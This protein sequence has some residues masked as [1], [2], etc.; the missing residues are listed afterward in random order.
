MRI[1]RIAY[2]WPPPWD[3]LAPA[4]YEMTTAQAKLGHKITVF[5]GRWPGAGDIETFSGVENVTFWREPL[6]GTVNLTTSILMFVYYLMWRRK[7]EVDVIHSHGHFGIW[8]YWWRNFLKQRKPDA[9]E[10]KTPLVVHFHN[11]VK[12]RAANLEENGSAIKDFSKKIAWPLAEKSDRWAV[13]NADA[14]IF[15]SE[16]TRNEAIKFYG[17]DASKCFVVESGVNVDLFKPVGAEE[18]YKTRSDLGFVQYDKI[19]LNHGV[20]V[21]RKNVHLLL[22]AMAKLPPNY[23]LLLVGPSPDNEYEITLRE[24]ISTYRLEDRVVRVGYTPYP[25]VP[26]A[27]Q[28]AD[29]F[30]L[31]SSWE[32]LPKV[33]MQSLACGVPVLASGFKTATQIQG[34]VYLNNLEV[35]NIARQIYETAEA[36]PK[37]DIKQIQLYHS[38][39]HMAKKV[40]QVYAKVMQRTSDNL[41]E[42]VV[43]EDQTSQF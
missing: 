29:L 14:M 17:A 28:A 33:V 24:K 7:N 40:D 42:N 18:S 25:E 27:F 15:V 23:K 36:D 38:W 35:D 37:V 1:L 12:G 26:I 39:H 43:T 16:E 8:V 41:A 21:E 31:P 2:E 19:I 13:Q 11:T 5:S 22:D 34:L 3:G 20:M 6:P 30:V 4:P 9:K 10:L 32:G